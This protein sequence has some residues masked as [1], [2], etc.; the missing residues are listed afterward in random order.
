MEEIIGTLIF[1]IIVLFYYKMVASDF[2]ISMTIG[3]VVVSVVALVDD[4]KNLS[5]MIRIIIYIISRYIVTL[6]KV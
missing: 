6:T 2:V 3:L 5:P 4:Y 1:T